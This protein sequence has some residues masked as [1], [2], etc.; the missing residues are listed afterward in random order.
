MTSNRYL[1]NV[2]VNWGLLGNDGHGDLSMRASHSSYC[3]VEHRHGQGK[4]VEY[5]IGNLDGDSFVLE[6]RDLSGGDETHGQ[7]KLWVHEY[8][9]LAVYYLA[10]V[11]WKTM[12]NLHWELYHHDLTIWVSHG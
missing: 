1:G 9:L 8:T 5:A 2:A 12:K 7:A 3:D 4:V 10:V 6:E 11:I